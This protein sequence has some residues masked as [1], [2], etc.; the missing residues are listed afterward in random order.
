[1]ERTI[2][3]RP[4]SEI[5][6]SIISEPVKVDK[7]LE[8]QGS[9][10][11]PREI[12]KSR[13]R[14]PY[15]KV[16]LPISITSNFLFDLFITSCNK[17]K[18][19]ISDQTPTSITGIQTLTSTVRNLFTCILPL[20][21]E[22]KAR[23]SSI[24]KLDIRLSEKNCARVVSI[25]GTYGFPNRIYPVIQMFKELLENTGTE[26][27]KEAKEDND[28]TLP[29]FQTA[30]YQ[31]SRFLSN[32]EVPSGKLF[33]AFIEEFLQ[34]Y[35][36]ASQA[37]LNIKELNNF[38]KIA[39]DGIN[40]TVIKAVPQFSRQAIEKYAYAKIFPHVK[41]IYLEKTALLSR[42]FIEKRNIY[43][44]ETN[45]SLMARLDIK[46]KFRIKDKNPYL[47]AIENLN[48]LDKHTSPIEKL[49]CILE[50]ATNMK[51]TVID[52]WKGKEELETMDDQLPVIIFIVC[53]T[54][55]DSLPAQIE[56]LIDYTRFNTG[57]DNEHRLLINYDAAISY[58]I[59]D[60]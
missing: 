2:G 6:S 57:V 30:Y 49:N 54:N 15:Y 22:K 19:H 1:M 23:T 46:E 55:L 16:V 18:F 12:G 50:S 5:N 48:S 26:F 36:N 51:T 21:E 58:I 52:Y 44:Q 59:N 39:L 45:E 7:S 40:D 25:K 47:S 13:V 17:H 28:Y 3:A 33:Q 43:S 37:A 32:N 4:E 10:I 35:G 41:K 24:V 53:K 60:M 38:I 56:F 42:N 14:L 27:V 20:S 8:I 11:S 29:T 31:I 9:S 34:K